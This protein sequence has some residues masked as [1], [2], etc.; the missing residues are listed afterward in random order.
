MTRFAVGLGQLGW[1]I[2]HWWN[3][4]D[5]FEWFSSYLSDRQLVEPTRILLGI[6]CGTASLVPWVI[7]LD[8]GGPENVLQRY[9]ALA[10]GVIGV[11]MTVMW[12]LLPW[13]S[14]TR[15]RSWVVVADLSILL[16]CLAQIHHVGAVAGCAVFGLVSGYI[17][18]F[19]GA[20][21]LAVHIGFSLVVACLLSVL[22]MRADTASLSTVVIGIIQAAAVGIAIPVATQFMLEVLASDAAASEMDTLTGVLNR[23]GLERALERLTAMDRQNSHGLAVMVADLDNFKEI[24]DHYGHR[25]GDR[26]LAEIAA[27]LRVAVGVGGVVAR[28]G[29]DEFVIAD[30]LR[31]NDPVRLANTVLLTISTVSDPPVTASVGVVHF[32]GVI[33]TNKSLMST[34]LFTD[35]ADAAMYEAKRAGGNTVRTRGHNYGAPSPAPVVR[36]TT[37]RPGARGTA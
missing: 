28:I 37:I 27:R 6:T 10:S 4:K 19:H 13:P 21:M 33:P 23:R 7:L 9:A 11:G 22:L 5:Q 18:F 12:L 30:S 26:V 24:N 3:R 36:P 32:T 20:R 15:S 34:V 2:S 14:A 8:A 1:A 25:Y 16:G 31:F 35:L 17:A 29:G